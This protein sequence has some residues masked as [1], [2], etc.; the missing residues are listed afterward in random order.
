MVAAPQR[1]CDSPRLL[2]LPKRTGANAVARSLGPVHI[3]F[4]CARSRRL[5]VIHSIS[6]SFTTI[7]FSNPFRCFLIVSLIALSVASA[8]A[9]DDPL[10]H[11]TDSLAPRDEWG[12]LHQMPT[13]YPTDFSYRSGYRTYYY[14]KSGR[15]LLTDPAY[16]GALQV[17]LRNRGYYCGPIDGV[18]SEEITDAIARLQ[19]NHAQRVT[20]KL[21]VPVRRALHL[22]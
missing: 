12:V 10:F 7:M 22:P 15:E 8:R 11:S 13:L 16:V 17:C 18:M 20:G 21:T 6:H 1:L 19:K 3:L 4:F 14:L 5:N 2:L 9:S